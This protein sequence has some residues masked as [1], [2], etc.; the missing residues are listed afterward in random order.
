MATLKNYRM[1]VGVLEAYDY[2]ANVSLSAAIYATYKKYFPEEWANSSAALE[3]E[4][5]ERFSPREEEF[6]DLLSEANIIPVDWEYF[7]QTSDRNPY[8][9]VETLSYEP[10]YDCPDTEGAAIVAYL[11]DMTTLGEIKWV[12][13][14]ANKKLLELYPKKLRRYTVALLGQKPPLVYLSDLIARLD[15]NTGNWWLDYSRDETEPKLWVE[16]D[17]LVKEWELAQPI[18]ERTR[19]VEEWIANNLDSFLAL[20]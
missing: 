6:F 3:R 9:P 20:L 12:I 19:Q 8:I 10:S 16:L 18:L 14:A 4:T 1:P 7:Y 2:L 5:W 11:M 15:R 13:T 17:F